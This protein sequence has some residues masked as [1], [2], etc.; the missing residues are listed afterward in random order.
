M[1]DRK[2]GLQIGEAESAGCAQRSNAL[3][4]ERDRKQKMVK[5]VLHHICTRDFKTKLSKSLVAVQGFEPR[6]LRI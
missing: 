3:G 5:T 2:R 6:K 1:E 4:K